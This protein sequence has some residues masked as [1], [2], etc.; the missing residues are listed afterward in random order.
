M[1][2]RFA[3]PWDDLA[4]A[5]LPGRMLSHTGTITIGAT[6]RHGN[7]ARFSPLAQCRTP[8]FGN[9]ATWIV[10]MAVRFSAL[11]ASPARFLAF[12][13]ADLEDQIELSVQSD[14][15]LR[16]ARGLGGIQIGVSAAAVVTFGVWY[17]IELK[18]TI[19]NAGSFNV[20]VNE[21]SVASDSA[22]TQSNSNAWAN[23]FQLGNQDNS[24]IDIDID[25]VVILDG[26]G[27]ANNDFPGDCT[28]H[29]LRPSGAGISAEWTP[30]AGANYAAVDD[31]TPDGDTTRVSASA[32]ERDTYA[33]GNLPGGVSSVVGVMAAFVGKEDGGDA[34]VAPALRDGGVDYTGTGQA[35]T[36]GYAGYFQAYDARPGGS[37]WSVAAVNAL[38]AGVERTA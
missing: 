27:S 17:W 24:G 4:T 37:A 23:K 5:D 38:E 9:H 34:S 20:R 2:F 30:S 8:Q 29:V 11:P 3:E 15:S 10:G 12:R 16:L 22:D 28:V 18:A 25:D 32:T 1:A 26:S 13:D 35:L 31:E 33:M 14:G 19:D 21:V 7:G 6:G 36:T